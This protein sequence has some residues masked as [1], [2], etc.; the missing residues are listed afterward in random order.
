MLLPAITFL[1]ALLAVSPP[2][3]MP[4]AEVEI[5]SPVYQEL[6]RFPPKWVCEQQYAAG[7][8]E[9]E[10]LERHNQKTP[11]NDYHLVYPIEHVK[12]DTEPWGVLLKSYD[13][14]EAGDVCTSKKYLEMLQ[15]L[16]GPQL[17]NAGC[18][19]PAVRS[20]YYEIYTVK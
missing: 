4:R 3:P 20:V 13:A 10:A 16:L 6:L 1:T 15:T 7:T 18:I 8:R 5:D 9:L 14:L 19:P 17:Y 11:T 12:T 2:S